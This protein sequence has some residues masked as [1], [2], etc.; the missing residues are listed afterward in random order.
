L[1]SDHF[2]QGAHASLSQFFPLG[3]SNSANFNGK[4]KKDF[5]AGL[6]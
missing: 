6:K 4:F 2:V 1:A 3:I 5:K